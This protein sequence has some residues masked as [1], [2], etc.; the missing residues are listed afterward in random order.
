MST[1]LRKMILTKKKFES[2]EIVL[3]PNSVVSFI[4][5]FGFFTFWLLCGN[6]KP[7]FDLQNLHTKINIGAAEEGYFLN[8]CMSQAD[9]S[10]SWAHS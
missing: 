7:A 4:K 9:K 5:G 10:S 3:K 2:W 1:V 8:S 6:S